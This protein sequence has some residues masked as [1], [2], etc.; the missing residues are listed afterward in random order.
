MKP[1]KAVETFNSYLKAT[2]KSA[3]TIKSYNYDLKTFLAFLEDKDIS[4]V[5]D[6]TTKTVIDYLESRKVGNNTKNRA[7]YA[8]KQLFT[9]LVLQGLHDKNPAVGIKSFKSEEKPVMTLS[10]ED[11]MKLRGVVKDDPKWNAVVELM[12]YLPL[13]VSEV[14]NLKE[15]D[16]SLNDGRITI[17]TSK[18]KKGRELPLSDKLRRI[19]KQYAVYKEAQAKKR[20]W[21][22]VDDYFFLGKAGRQLTPRS[23]RHNFKIFYKKARIDKR[24]STHTLR[25][26]VC[27][28]YGIK[29]MDP[30]TLRELAGHKDLKTTQ[31]Y[32]SVMLKDK[33]NAIE[34]LEE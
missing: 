23:V 4:D 18:N 29:G 6:V 10:E 21:R 19:M 34:Q 22:D 5:G 12:L 13:R 20:K 30:F 26:T 2:G 8:L 24:A 9:C 3:N 28:R 16:V 27:T 7:L 15:E 17:R 25:H 33:R 31:R 1:K 32:V 11:E 14:C